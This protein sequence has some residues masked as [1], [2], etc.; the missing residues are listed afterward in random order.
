[1]RTE[2]LSLIAQ[3]MESLDLSADKLGESVKN[4][5]VED[6]K[7][8]KAEIINLQKQLVKIIGWIIWK[9][10]FF[11][12]LNFQKIGRNFKHGT[13]KFE[14]KYRGGKRTC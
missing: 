2:D 4:N 7:K 3:I 6:T 1:M 5:N 8:I 14:G 10:K 13:W 11:N 12:Y 9:I